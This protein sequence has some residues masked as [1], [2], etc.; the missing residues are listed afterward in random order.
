MAACS[1]NHPH[2]QCGNIF[3]NDNNYNDNI[4][5]NDN[6]NINNDSNNDDKDDNDNNENNDV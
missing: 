2:Q 6:S 5:G 4:T 1:M 3:C